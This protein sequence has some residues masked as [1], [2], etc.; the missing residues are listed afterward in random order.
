MQRVGTAQI[1]QVHCHVLY[2]IQVDPGKPDQYCVLSHRFTEGGVHQLLGITPYPMA[3][4]IAVADE[5][6]YRGFEYVR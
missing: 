2:G 4:R 3:W 1:N 5:Q 6:E